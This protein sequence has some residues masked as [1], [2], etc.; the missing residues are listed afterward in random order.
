MWS[1]QIKVSTSRQCSMIAWLSLGSEQGVGGM[2]GC[3]CVGVG[4]YALMV[5]QEGGG[6][7]L[8][9]TGKGGE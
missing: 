3:V 5:G 2:G 4:G 9:V 1:R 7:T 6:A 8:R